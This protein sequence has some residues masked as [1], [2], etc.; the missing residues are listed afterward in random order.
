MLKTELTTRQQ[1]FVAAMIAGARTIEQAAT[2]AGVTKR[3]GMR[4]M[5]TPAIKSAI[6]QALDAVLAVAAGQAVAEMSDALATLR[7][8]HQDAD[9]PASARVSAARAILEAGPRLREAL[10]LAERVTQ[11]EQAMERR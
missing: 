3:T 10:D 4:Y 2:Q 9:A 6:S 1:R 5:K 7:Q 8:I 11:L